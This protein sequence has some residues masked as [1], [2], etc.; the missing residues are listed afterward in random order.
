MKL[1]CG[2]WSGSS[3]PYRWAVAWDHAYQMHCSIA[4]PF[5]SDLVIRIMSVCI[6]SW[7][8]WL[9]ILGNAL[10]REKPLIRTCLEK[11]TTKWYVNDGWKCR[12]VN[13][14]A[15]ESLGLRTDRCRLR[16]DSILL[17]MAPQ[18]MKNIVMSLAYVIVT[19]HGLKRT[20][21]NW[22]GKYEVYDWSNKRELTSGTE[23]EM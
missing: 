23:E 6:P 12:A 17:T 1:H 7:Y 16:N 14:I 20:F 18:P 2:H 11:V 5:V 21:K 19:C 8:E 22:Q 13:A 4:A 10:W 3:D 9:R 15:D